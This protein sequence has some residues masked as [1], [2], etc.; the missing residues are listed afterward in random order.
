MILFIF[1]GQVEEPK[2]MA[3]LEQLFL[4][5]IEEQL[6]CSYGADTY[7]LW[8]DIVEYI[9]DKFFLLKEEDTSLFNSF[10]P[11]QF[12]AYRQQW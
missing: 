5:R 1:E 12:L 2:I 9:I 3:T 6:I 8:K 4:N 7:T 10:T 11:S